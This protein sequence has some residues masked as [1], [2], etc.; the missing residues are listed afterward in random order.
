MSALLRV[1]ETGPR[2]RKTYAVTDAGVAEVQRWL[3]ETQPDRTVR[4]EPILRLFM[5]WLLESPEAIAFFDDEIESHR[6]RLIG[7]EQ[8][9]ADD[10]HQRLE[11]G[12]A[13]GGIAFCASLALEWG[14]RYEREYIDWAKQAR[15]RI[16]TGAKA[17]DD[18]RERKLGQ[19]KATA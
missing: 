4:N 16:A 11:H 6:Q 15:G 19:H 1:S 17:W 8:T 18:E 14:I 10:E 9:L 3:R 12:T 13:Q 7:F 5:L 2:R